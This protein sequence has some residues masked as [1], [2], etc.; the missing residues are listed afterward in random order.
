[1]FVILIVHDSVLGVIFSLQEVAGAD[2]SVP[3]LNVIVAPSS[4]NIV[5]VSFPLS[6]QYKEFIV[7]NIR[8]LFPRN[9]KELKKG[10][11]L[12]T[13]P[14]SLLKVATV[15]EGETLS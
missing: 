12:E 8:N 2:K 3:N 11:H 10:S 7:F 4:Y 14:H 5:G 6:K 15:T 13:S 1:M 9:R